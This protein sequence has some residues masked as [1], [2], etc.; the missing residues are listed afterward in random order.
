MTITT[1]RIK[2]QPVAKATGRERTFDNACR[3]T[4]VWPIQTM[5]P[6]NNTETKEMMTFKKNIDATSNDSTFK[7]FFS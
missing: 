6:A 2:R 3:S 5:N 7:P 1:P 4:P